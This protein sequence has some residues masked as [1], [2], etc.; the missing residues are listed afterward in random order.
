MRSGLGTAPVGQGRP[1]AGPDLWAAVRLGLFPTG[2][3]R[4]QPVTTVHH[5]CT[6]CGET[7][8]VIPEGFTEETWREHEVRAV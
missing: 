7:V 5:V 8:L 1:P 2:P 4:R 6:D 3:L